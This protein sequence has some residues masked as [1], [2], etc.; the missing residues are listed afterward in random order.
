MLVGLTSCVKA[1]NKVMVLEMSES[2]KQI[3]KVTEADE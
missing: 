3:K 1:P 2:E